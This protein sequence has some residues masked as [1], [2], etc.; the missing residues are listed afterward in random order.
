[1]SDSIS[2][3]D[4]LKLMG[5]IGV[6]TMA[7]GMALPARAQQATAVLGHFGSANPQTLGKALNSFGK[8]FGPNVKTDFVTVSGGPQVLAAIAGNSMDVCNVGSSPMVVGFA[9][10][11]KM[12]MVYVE[13]YITDSECLAVR[14]D[15]GIGTMRDLKGK[16]IGLPFNT[17]VHF[18][19]LAGMK[20]AGLSTSD[21]QLVN[22]KADSIQ[23]TWQ[24]KDIDGAYIWHPVLGDLVADNGKI[25]L[26]TGDLAASGILV[27]DGI[28]VR[29]DFKKQHP[30]LVLAYLKEY[31]RLCDM[32]EKQP[33]E[34]V[35]VLAPYLAMTPEKTMDY[36]KT[37]HALPPKELA[38]EKWMG[39]PG[40]KDTGVLRTLQAQGEFLKTADPIPSLPSTWAPYID[41]TFLA[42]MA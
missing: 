27:F 41:S 37:F 3:R 5:N 13:K 34:V 23:A 9:Q 18:A 30:E 32:Y 25:I 20:N 29:D 4:A 21:V 11:I 12:S 15:A 28:V 40:S 39:M 26:K 22:V 8:A 1:M 10:G 2:R 16:K 35:K 33:A 24:R 42:R 38:S 14:N 17:S 36:I 7:G 6:V 31:A 19:M